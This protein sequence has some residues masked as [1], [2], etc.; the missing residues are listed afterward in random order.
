MAPQPLASISYLRALA[1]VAVVESHATQGLIGQAGVDV[2][3]VIS[4]FIMWTITSTETAPHVFLLRRVIRIVP[5]Y[6]VAT[7]IMAIHQKASFSA[8]AKS[9][10]FIPF[11]GE[12]GMIWPVLVPGWTL[13]YEMSFYLLVGV[14]LLLPR[15]IQLISLIITLCLLSLLSPVVTLSG[16]PILLTYTNPIVLEFLAGILLAESRFQSKIPGLV[17]GSFALIIGVAGLWFAPMDSATDIWRFVLWGAPSFLLVAGMVILEA[18]GV[19]LSSAFLIF[20]GDASYSLYLSHTF[21]VMP[22]QRALRAFPSSV[23]VVAAIITA[24]IAGMLLYRFVERPVTR[25]LRRFSDR[26][27]AR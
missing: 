9:L 8:V 14:T 17:G 16:D 3:F 21:V 19:M 5:L 22:V 27:L 25:A 11:F 10:C 20:S 1:A 7:V 2:F 18:R 15:Y 12:K 26:R 6:W 24:C 4:G 13:N 23:G